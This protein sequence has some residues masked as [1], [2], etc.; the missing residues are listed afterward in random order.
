MV[1]KSFMAIYEVVWAWWMPVDCGRI[2]S[3]YILT[4]TS[5]KLQSRFPP[6]W[7]KVKCSTSSPVTPE[8]VD[9]QAV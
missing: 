8:A 7:N 9:V 6:P 1:N 4:K 5:I 2:S 3:T